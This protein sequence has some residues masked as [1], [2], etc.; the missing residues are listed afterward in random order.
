M[1]TTIQPPSVINPLT[2][3]KTATEL[4]N[5]RGGASIGLYSIYKGYIYTYTD[6]NWRRLYRVS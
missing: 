6:G 1:N 2:D 3:P 5:A 4:Y